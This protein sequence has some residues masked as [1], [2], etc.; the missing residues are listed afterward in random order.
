MCTFG[1]WLSWQKIIIKPILPFIKN[2][3][4]N[5]K[6]SVFKVLALV[7][8]LMLYVI[9]CYTMCK[10]YFLY[11]YFNDSQIDG[12]VMLP[13]LDEFGDEDYE[14]VGSPHMPTFLLLYFTYYDSYST[15]RIRESAESIYVEL[16]DSYRIRDYD[17]KL[18]EISLRGKTVV[19]SY[20]E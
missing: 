5:L 13:F 7:R 10:I 1:N 4:S 19:C 15:A 11:C 12:T 6:M 18:I 8:N 17:N 14:D 9:D 16:K 20:I 2:Y 3:K